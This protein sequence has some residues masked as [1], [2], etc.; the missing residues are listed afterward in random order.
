MIPR[1]ISTRPFISLATTL[2][3]GVCLF[4]IYTKET[5][6]KVDELKAQKFSKR[7]GEPALKALPLPIEYSDS[8]SEKWL[9][10]RVLLEGE[11]L[12]EHEIYLENRVSED[13]PKPNSKKANGFHIMMPF[14]LSSGQIVWGNLFQAIFLLVKKVFLRCH[15]NLLTSLM[16]MSLHLISTYMTTKRICPTE[17]YT[18]LS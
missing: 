12:P 15:Q 17:M 10:R 18:L 3:V 7:N 16:A 4:F 5:Q 1:I 6:I 9:Y 14:L 8:F 13:A 2:V 11:F